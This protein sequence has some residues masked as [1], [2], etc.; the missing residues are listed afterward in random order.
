MPVAKFTLDPSRPPKLSAMTKARLD[1]MTEDEVTAAARSD[2]DNPPLTE[3]EFD[4]M[5][6]AR[7]AKSA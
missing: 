1:A 3:A 7:I 4:R 5:G 2:P 6:A